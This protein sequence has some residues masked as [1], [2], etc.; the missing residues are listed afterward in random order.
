MCG[1]A[2]ALHDFSTEYSP[3]EEPQEDERFL[4]VLCGE[5]F[6]LKTRLN[7]D[8]ERLQHLMDFEKEQKTDGKAIRH[9]LISIYCRY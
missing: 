5:N 8:I 4:D 7:K 9:T 6:D 2:L 3:F 1:V